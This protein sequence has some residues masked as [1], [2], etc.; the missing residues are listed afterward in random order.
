M[1]WHLLTFGVGT[2]AKDSKKIAMTVARKGAR[3]QIA[4][5]PRRREK[6][7]T[8]PILG[9]AETR[10]TVITASVMGMLRLSALQKA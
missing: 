6:T 5:H 10:N 1:N 8:S 7:R 4:K 2:K 3:V 9:E